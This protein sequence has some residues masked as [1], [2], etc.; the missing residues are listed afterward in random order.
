LT[1]PVSFRSS[2]VSA[3]V[4]VS[5]L[6]GCG[7]GPKD[8]SP[9]VL[10]GNG[11]VF[12]APAGW[13]VARNARELSASKGEGLVSV[14]VFRLTRAYRPALFARASAEL[15]RVARELA[16]GLKGRVTGQRTVIVDDRR[17]RQY[18]VSYR[19]L[20]QVVT[21]VLVDRREYQ[22]LCRRAADAD[23]SACAGLVSSFSLS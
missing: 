7:G 17:A 16:Q 9:Q 20:L 2:L 3:V 18:V 23:D 10:E 14:R 19:G 21:F 12:A 4:I 6:A 13:D 11:F 5:I 1:I 22:L 15:D 8:Q